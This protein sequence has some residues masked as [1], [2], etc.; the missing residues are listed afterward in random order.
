M[1]EILLVDDDEGTRLLFVEIAELIDY[2]IHT[3]STGEEFFQLYSQQQPDL[4]VLDLVMPNMDGLELMRKLLSMQCKLPIL[5][6]SGYDYINE[7]GL[8]LLSHGLNF[9]GFIK[10]PFNV[11]E[12]QKLIT[13]VMQHPEPAT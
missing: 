8:E 12:L 13:E 5:V 10:K 6:I 7:E 3:A 4:L 2:G 11:A 9:K 1:P